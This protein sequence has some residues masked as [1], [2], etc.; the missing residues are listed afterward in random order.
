MEVLSPAGD[1]NQLIAGV[2]AGCDAV[3]GGLKLWNAR[4]RAKNFTIEEYIDAVSYCKENNV[5]FYLTINTLM[6]DNEIDEIMNVL[7]D[8]EFILPDAVIASDFG[9]IKVLTKELPHLHIHASTQFGAHCLD[10]ITFLEKLGIKRIILSREL[11]MDEIKYLKCNTRSQLEV[12]VWGVQCIGFSG[13]CYWG[14]LVFGGSGS[15]GK[16]LALCRDIYSFNNRKCNFFYS[17]DLKAFCKAH[18][19]NEIGID[20]IK[21]EGRRSRDYSEIY[22]TVS[23]FKEA[24]NANYQSENVEVKNPYCGYLENKLPVEG[25]IELCN[26]RNIV[27]NIPFREVGQLDL[28]VVSNELGE[29]GYI[30]ASELNKN[31]GTVGFVKSRITNKI[32]RGKRNFS[33]NI[34]SNQEDII[35][36]IYVIGNKGEGKMFSLK[37]DHD[38]IQSDI[39][40]IY[41]DILDSLNGNTLSELTFP[42][43]IDYKLKFNKNDY[44]LVMNYIKEK[45]AIPNIHIERNSIS[46]KKYNILNDAISIEVNDI[47]MI[48]ALDKAGV[49]RIIYNINNIDELSIVLEQYGTYQN[50]IYKLPYFDWKS[51][52]VK[53]LANLLNNQNIMITRL[54][55]ISILEYGKFKSM[56]ADY[57]VHCWNKRTI[58]SLMEYGINRIT[59][60]PEISF[61]DAIKV[62]SDVNIKLEIIFAGHIPL[63]YTR[64]CFAESLNC[65]AECNKIKELINIDKDMKFMIRCRQ[66]HREIFYENPILVDVKNISTL[67]NGTTFRYICNMH[68][69]EELLNNI[70]IM[71][72]DQHYYE[73]LLQTTLWRNSYV[74]NLKESVR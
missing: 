66:S 7:K 49:N 72:N 30:N 40:I 8:E 28:I 1:M 20:S 43:T 37:T 69:L 44:D 60:S 65:N 4:N 12:F 39:Y 18:D 33:I 25:L 42:K 53:H 5:K 3:Y 73:K 10:D 64:H 14:S 55:Q 6:Y 34:M 45:S 9:L 68:N 19:L 32:V 63:A 62:F 26:E 38:L 13:I 2:K 56:E 51:V 46:E 27:R 48:A 35:N 24:L 52:G 54:S 23:G 17:K 57:T 70:Q 36:C 61:E 11:L 50:I 31:V 41:R 67:P 22:N 47:N 21:I 71:K 29:P 59:L 58:N 74:G 15:R 16:C